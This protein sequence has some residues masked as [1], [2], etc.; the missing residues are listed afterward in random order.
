VPYYEGFSGTVSKIGEQKYLIK[1]KYERIDVDR[2]QITEL[3]IGTWTMNYITFLEELADGSTDKSGKKN[4]PVIKDFVNISTEVNVHITITFPKG[5]IDELLS[6]S[7]STESIDPIEKLL[8]L[9]TTITTT[10]MNLFDPKLQLH[11][12]ISVEEI[13]DTFYEVRMQTYQKRKDAI[14]KIW[15]DKL[16]ELSNRAKYI[17]GNLDGVI[18]L[19]RKKNQEVDDLLQKMKFDKMDDSFQYL[20]KM[21]MDCVTEENVAKIMKEKVDKEI[22]IKTLENTSLADLWLKDLD[23]FYRKYLEYKKEREFLQY[24]SG[25]SSSSDNK[26]K[27]VHKVTKSKK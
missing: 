5:K 20:R 15:K 19:R 14:L 6:S 23:V 13:I 1:G 10:N 2:I 4:P 25:S 8:K 7:N 24:H 22:E 16:V 12:Y 17:Q 27:V 26:K 11:K 21:Q 18:D 9:T 3:P